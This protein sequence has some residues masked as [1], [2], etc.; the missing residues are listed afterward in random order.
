MR[1]HRYLFGQYMQVTML[2]LVSLIMV[3][4]L[5]QTLQL[6]ELVVNKGSPLIGFIILSVLAMPL[7]LLQA[8]PIALFIAILW[9]I[10]KISTDREF[11]ALQSVGWSVRQ[12]ALTPLFFACLC[13]AFLIFNSVILLPAGFGEFKTRQLELRAAIPKI[14]LQDKVFVDLAPN[15]TIFINER[16]SRSEV[17]NVFIQD[18]RD[19]KN[20]TTLTASKGTFT[21]ENGQAILILENGERS[22]IGQG[23]E[24][25]ATLFFD[26]YKLNFSRNVKTSNNERPLDMNEDSI[27]NLLDPTKAIS[28]KYARQRIAYGHYRII[29]PFLAL[30]LA[31]IAVAGVSRGRLR[32]EHKNYRFWGTIL[33]AIFVQILFI[34]ARS[35]T[36]TIPLFWPLQYAVILT[37]IFIGLILIYQP[38]W[39]QFPRLKGATS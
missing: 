23:G 24:A 36:F 6:L 8:V 16:V 30:T 32:D 10:N 12:F 11:V 19:G 33:V 28:E 29:S 31:V 5:N 7:W 21:R 35:V 17:K 1:L 39:L 3:V 14:L 34:T 20:I 13:T 38:K 9:V 2:V 18:K 15:L 26:E 25:S 27:L 4:W 37:P 22:Q